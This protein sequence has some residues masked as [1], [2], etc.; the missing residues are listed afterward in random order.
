M[1]V[2][3]LFPFPTHINV[4]SFVSVKFTDQNY[5]GWKT[6]MEALLRG[7]KLLGFVNGH[8]KPPS[9]K[10]CV[11]INNKVTEVSN[12]DHESWLQTDQLVQ[13]WLFGTLSEEII[14]YAY[15]LTYARDVWLMIEENFNQSSISREFDL[16]ASI[17]VITKG[18]KDLREYLREFK[19]LCDQLSSIGKPVSE[20]MKIFYLLQSL[21][22]EFESFAT[23]IQTSMHKPP[24]P[25]YA[26]VASQ[27]IGF[28]N[29]IKAYA[30][31]SINPQMA[32]RVQSNG[33]VAN[34]SSNGQSYHGYG[35]GG[36]GSNGGR[37]GGSCGRG[38]YS[39]RGRGFTQ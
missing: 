19:A 25:T 35:Q 22:K 23:S 17:H 11:K 1:V 7:Q 31:V 18:N 2:S 5:L 37:S 4:S 34:F 28:D 30:P 29:R 36:R 13:S 8:Q 26:E 15:G 16:L 21:G 38:G 20:S 39:F 32:F 24:V 14:G 3:K 6:Q 27:L 9:E 12:P 10:I 33:Q